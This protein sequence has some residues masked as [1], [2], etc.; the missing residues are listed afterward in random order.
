MSQEEFFFHIWLFQKAKY[1]NDWMHYAVV[2]WHGIMAA[3]NKWQM[4]QNLRFWFFLQIYC[5]HN[6]N[7]NHLLLFYW[8][9]YF[10]LWYLGLY[11]VHC[12]ISNSFPT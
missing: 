7:P 10:Q 4:T 9:L 8:H 5:A 2:R 12:A 1:E 3:A 6:L 11:Q